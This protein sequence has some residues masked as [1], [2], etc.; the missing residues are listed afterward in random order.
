MKKIIYLLPLL[1]TL[2]LASTRSNAQ[3]IES[4]FI[5]HSYDVCG[6]YDC[7]FIT[8]HYASG[9]TLKFYWGD[10]TDD[11]VPVTWWYV[12]TGNTWMNHLYT[13][14]GSYS[15]KVVLYDGGPV[16]SVSFTQVVSIC[17]FVPVGGFVDA[18]ANC[19]YD[20]GDSYMY[21]ACSIRVD[22]AGVPIDIISLASSFWYQEYGPVGT[23][24]A[25]TLL[26][27]PSGLTL[28]CPAGGVLYDTVPTTYTYS[29]PEQ[30]FGFNCIS[31][32]APFDLSIGASMRPALA[33]S[34]ANSA[35]ISVSNTSCTPT[36]GMVRF[37]FSPKY[38]FGS[39]SPAFSHTVAGTS[40]TVDVGSVSAY[41]MTYFIV[42][43]TPVSPLVLGD[44]V[45]S[46]FTVTPIT[47]DSNPVNNIVIRCDT[48][49]ASCDPNHKSVTPTG[50]IMP[51]TTL[52]YMLEFENTGNDTAH[53]IHIL[54]TLSGYLDVSTLKAGVS[55]HKMG[56][57]YYEDGPYKIVK[58][59]FPNIMLPDTSHHD[60]CRGMVTFS[61]KAKLALPMGTTITNR[62]GIYFDINDV[63]MTNTVTSYYPWTEEVKNVGLSKVELYPNPVKETLNI[64]MEGGAYNTLTIYNIVGQSIGTQ[65]MNKAITSV[66]VSS[67]IPGIYYIALKGD[68]GTRTIKFEKQ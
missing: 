15:M 61:V 52:E 34:G 29:A 5:A 25:F 24:Y 51:G 66:N 68:A 21:G 47:G 57:F 35:N 42:Y 2:A 10:G 36:A 38:T 14:A 62:V 31:S 16:D 41:S 17:R 64:T 19:L 11:I 53:N 49:R 6:S 65:D 22:S 40:V 28:A 8:T 67:L 7:R 4:Y 59:D 48:V 20:V 26:T 18:N 39:L 12:D 58:F 60:V 23:V 1:F 43:L 63:V 33:G 56:M 37:D 27:P 9:Q 30:L 55:S 54:D 50:T 45:N 13:S 3:S 44:T 32:S 46:I